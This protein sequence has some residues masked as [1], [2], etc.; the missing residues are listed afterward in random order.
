MTKYIR[1][2][3]CVAA[4][5]ISSAKLSLAQPLEIGSIHPKRTQLFIVTEAFEPLIFSPD[6]QLRGIDY[7]T[8]EAVFRI[9]NIPLLSNFIPSNGA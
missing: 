9:L 5:F 1:Y 4:I 8:T 3:I 2:L 7:E 6:A